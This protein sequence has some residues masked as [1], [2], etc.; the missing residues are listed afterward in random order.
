MLKRLWKTDAPLTATGLMM[1]PVLAILAVGLIVD[2]RLTT[3]APAWLQAREVRP[4]DCRLGVSVVLERK[5]ALRCISSLV[6]SLRRRFEA[7]RAISPLF[8]SRNCASLSGPNMAR[9]Q[10]VWANLL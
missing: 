10:Q 5:I 4:V 3:G 8:V 9:Q 7:I 2:A 6:S 1:L